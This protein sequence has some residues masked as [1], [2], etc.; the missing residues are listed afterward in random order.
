LPDWDYE[1]NGPSNKED[2]LDYE[3]QIK[4]PDGWVC[5]KMMAPL[6]P[7]SM[8]PQPVQNFQLI[9]AG[10]L[11]VGSG[12]VLPISGWAS[13]TY[14]EKIPALACILYITHLLPIEFK[15]EWI[16]PCEG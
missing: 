9:R 12:S 7:E 1:I 16:F 2:S 6:K 11:L 13:P 4:S 14:G 8:Y 15:S 10:K 5:L 3:I